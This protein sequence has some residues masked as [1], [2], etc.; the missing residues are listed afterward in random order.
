MTV[1]VPY[2]SKKLLITAMAE[3]VAHTAL[4]R[5]TPGIMGCFT[6]QKAL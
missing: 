1:A 5:S 2:V 3:D 4:I 6:L